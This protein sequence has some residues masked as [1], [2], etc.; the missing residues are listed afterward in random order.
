M[1]QLSII[2]TLRACAGIALPLLLLLAYREGLC[3][4]E[5]YALSVSVAVAFHVITL[6]LCKIIKVLRHH[7]YYKIVF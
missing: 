2:G 4:M 7:V 5:L 6:I 1:C 3:P